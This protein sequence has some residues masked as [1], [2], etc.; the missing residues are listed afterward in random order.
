MSNGRSQSLNLEIDRVTLLTHRF[1]TDMII[2]HMKIPELL[3]RVVGP[4]VAEKVW[5]N[6]VTWTM[7][8]TSG[9]GAELLDELGLEFELVER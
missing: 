5:H 6:T 7:D 4:E 1:G 8:F 3:R 2:L 9:K